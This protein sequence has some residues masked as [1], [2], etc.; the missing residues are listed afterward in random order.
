MIPLAKAIG[1]GLGCCMVEKISNHTDPFQA[2]EHTWPLFIVYVVTQVIDA[3]NT[4][5]S[6]LYVLGILNQCEFLY[7]HVYKALF[8]LFS[9]MVQCRG[10]RMA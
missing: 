8:T 2:L 5:T 10:M 1:F 9:N 6:V 7:L 3:I 4:L